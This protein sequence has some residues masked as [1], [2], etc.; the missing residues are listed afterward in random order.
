MAFMTA[1]SH[2]AEVRGSSN[3]F[4]KTPEGSLTKLLVH[5][6]SACGADEVGSVSAGS[7][8]EERLSLSGEGDGVV[9]DEHEGTLHLIAAVLDGLL[10]ALHAAD[11]H[12]LDGVADGRQ[13]SVADGQRISLH[14]ADD[15]AGSRQ[16]LSVLAGILDVHDALEAI[17]G[18]GASLAAHQNDL[19]VVAADSW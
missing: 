15:S 7:K 17:A 6:H 5:R 18:A 13:G 3:F 8:V 10:A 19:A 11:G 4:I 12:S 16:L 14:S 1:S 9:G 2:W